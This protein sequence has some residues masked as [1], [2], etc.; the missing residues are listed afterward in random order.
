MVGTGGAAPLSRRVLLVSGAALALAGCG[1]GPSATS[2]AAPSPAGRG[3]GA[4]AIK[5]RITVDLHSHAGRVNRAAGDFEPLAEPMR[6]G[7]MAVVCLAFSAD[8][9]VTQVTPDKRIVAFRQPNPGELYQWSEAAFRR[10]L[11]IAREQRLAIVTDAASFRA[12]SA[13]GPAIIV[14]CE[15]ADFLDGSITRVEEAYTRHRLRQ[16]QLTHYRV[17]ALGDIQTTTPEHGGLTPFGAEVIRACNRLGI[18]VDVAHGTYDLVKQAVAVATKPLVLSHT[19][20]AAA[21]RPG[22][23]LISADHARLVAGTGGVIG[24]W[25][26]S[27]AFANLRAFAE[28]MA[29][30]AEVVGVDHVGLGSD[31]LGIP[32]GVV[33]ESYRELPDLAGALLAAGFRADEAAKVLGEN[34][35]RVFT[36]VAA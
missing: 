29:R 32:G 22:S 35:A 28:G 23:R 26:P 6:A 21:P 8:R 7:G 2:P 5:G 25:P 30:M 19:S 16:L 36:A 11:A 10:I 18:V 20:L 3:A 34:Y 33:F 31:M 27:F 14:T 13:E 15:G 17:N 12:A 4:D 9:P 24:I 1:A